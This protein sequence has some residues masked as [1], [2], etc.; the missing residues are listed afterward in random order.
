MKKNG[1]KVLYC[2]SSNR[3]LLHFHIPYIQK[4]EK[5]GV[6]VD[7]L[8]S[9][10]PDDFPSNDFI[11]IPFYK[12]ILSPKNIKNIVKIRSAILKGRYDFI[13]LNTSL[14]AALVRLAIP[15]RLVKKTKVV[16]ISHG[17]FFGVNIPKKRSL[18]FKIIEKVLSRRTD[19]IITMNG[20]D[21]GYAKDYKLCKSEVFFVH[22]MGYNEK[23]YNTAVRKK[24][25]EK[26]IELLY[27]AEHSERK[28]HKE[29]FYAMKTAVENGSDL[30]LQLAGDG[31][32]MDENR[33]LTKVLGLDSRITFLGYLNDVVKV[34]KTCDYVVSP[35][36]IEGLPFNIMEAMACGIP[37]VV[38]DIKGHRDLVSNGENGYVYS[39]GDKK[40]LSEILT[41]LDK[42][43][44]EYSAL[45]KSASES[46]LKNSLPQTLE[47]FEKIYNTIL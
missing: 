28:N 29:L 8:S 21:F 6:R 9:G 1:T 13:I 15:S 45:C 47:E 42:S 25:S 26:S 40:K 46:V 37:C 18:M 27:V 36:K 12:S 19:Y 44:K 31:K 24:Q 33:E 41:G 4:L 2:A 14:T 30:R 10:S 23:K 39:Q 35:S 22:G 43:S 32:L 3:H 20:E 5:M 34:Y 7:I 17:Y 11:D 16:N 38:S